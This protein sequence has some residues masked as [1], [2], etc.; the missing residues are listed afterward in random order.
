MNSQY[1][2]A[3]ELVGLVGMAGTTQ[4]VNKA[5][6]TKGWQWRKKSGK[7][8][9]KAYA[10][11]SL[12]AETQAALSQAQH[13]HNKLHN[14]H[15]Q[16]GAMAGTMLKLKA[17]SVEI[18]EESAREQGLADATLLQGKARSRM[19]ARIAIMQAFDQ[20]QISYDGATSA[21]R[22]AFA[23]AFNGGLIAVEAWVKE[24]VRD[25]KISAGSLM[26]WQQQLKKQGLA[27]LSGGYG[28]RKGSGKLDQ[29][30]EQREFV[31][32]LICEFNHASAAHYYEALKA[33]FGEPPIL[34]MRSLQRWVNQYKSEHERSLLRYT[35]PDAYKDKVMFASGS[36]SDDVVRLNQ[37]WELDSTPADVMLKEGRYSIIGMIDVYSRRVLL[38]VCKTSS[39]DGIVAMLRKAIL[40]FG[41]PERVKIDN[42]KDY[43]SKRCL[44][45]FTALQ[46][47]EVRSEAFSGWQKPHI[48]RFF[49]TFNRGICPALPNFA[50]HNVADAQALR[51]KK[52]FAEQLYEKNKVAEVDMTAADFQKVCD[53]WVNGYYHL[54]KHGELGMTPMQKATEW[55]GG[56]SQISN[57][58]ALDM[59]MSP[60][61]SNQGWRSITKRGISV[62]WAGEPKPHYYNDPAGC[63]AEVDSREKVLVRYD[64]LGSMGILYVFHNQQFLGTVENPQLLGLSRAEHGVI[65]KKA[66][67]KIA[68]TLQKEHKQ[69][70]K[71]QHIPSIAREM[72][73]GYE[74]AAQTVVA[75]P[76]QGIEHHT[77]DLDAV[78]Q[79]IEAMETRKK[80]PAIAEPSR[81]ML[82]KAEAA[83]VAAKQTDK[84]RDPSEKFA[85]YQAIQANPSAEDADKAWAKIWQTSSEY[86]AQILIHKY[87]QKE[88]GES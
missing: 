14:E 78:V 45:I 3:R 74:K 25:G 47:E 80:A 26:R 81:A 6:R 79:A 87:E 19:D 59:L 85:R 37:R 8:G 70:V 63:L 44:G 2:T 31:I 84:E 30:P 38:H 17:M 66:Q 67:N 29:H 51:A 20:Y 40:K 75:L 54:K 49:G 11:A 12:P 10:F 24:H 4:G 76:P 60:V 13:E 32:A 33:R 28:N 68:A 56:V 69:R 71:E 36:Y 62:T 64:P 15:A 86:R 58:R 82:E 27:S 18:T 83:A 53:T 73:E 88:G 5:A 50:G 21:A 1:Y 46:I 57:E 65:T 61:P 7:G 35:N 39:A 52:S 72:L 55:Q 16:A 23:D 43:I 77:P 48:E 22:Y 41:V 42:G 34:S 9:G